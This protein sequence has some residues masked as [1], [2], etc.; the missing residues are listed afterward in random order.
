MNSQKPCCLLKDLDTFA[1]AVANVRTLVQEEMK[2]SCLYNEAN[3][4]KIRKSSLL[5]LQTM[6]NGNY[7]VI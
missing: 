6:K 3:D 5:I 7:N 2:I 1:G 4:L